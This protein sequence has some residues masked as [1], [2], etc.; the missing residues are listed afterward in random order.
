M[1]DGVILTP[2]KVIADERG[3]VRHMLKTTDPHFLAFGEV[4]F[5]TV[6]AG[7]VKAWHLHQRMT[8]NYACVAGEVVVGLIDLRF[9]SPTFKQQEMCVLGTSGDAYQLLTI[10]PMIWN[11]FRIPEGSAFQEA[12]VANCATLPHDPKEISRIHPND[13]PE[14]F[15][16]GTY[17]TAG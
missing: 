1:I 11:G 2:L 16:W 17:W 15:D 6:K 5:S 8:L 9:G 12:M 13:F 7:V 10:P 3:S 14:P 4:Y